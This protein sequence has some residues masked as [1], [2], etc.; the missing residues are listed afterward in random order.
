MNKRVRSVKICLRLPCVI[1]N[2]QA[3][4][5]FNSWV[6]NFAYASNWR[7]IAFHD[8]MWVLSEYKW[9]KSTRDES[10]STVLVVN[11]ELRFATYQVV[12][13]IGSECVCVFL[14]G[15]VCARCP[16]DEPMRVASY[17]WMRKR[18]KTA[19]GP[20]LIEPFFPLT[21]VLLGAHAHGREA[22][23]VVFPQGICTITADKIP[24]WAGEC[25]VCMCSQFFTIIS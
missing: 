10:T 6:A 23:N 20:D 17:Q 18:Y 8:F 19:Y 16:F 1:R 3:C 2:R 15:F 9:K 22:V 11:C 7:R 21:V 4:N 13:K 24:A 12:S 5:Y 14:R 25:W